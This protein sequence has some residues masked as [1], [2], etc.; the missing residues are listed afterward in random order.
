MA[1]FAPETMVSVSSEEIYA[2]E[3][4]AATFLPSASTQRSFYQFDCS[5]QHFGVL[6]INLGQFGD[7]D[8]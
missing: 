4:K 3:T 1:L 6:E 7:H 5:A 8:N 2:G